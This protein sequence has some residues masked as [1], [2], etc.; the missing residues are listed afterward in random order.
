MIQVI[1]A[2]NNIRTTFNTEVLSTEL[3]ARDCKHLFF[4][5]DCKIYKEFDQDLFDRTNNLYIAFISR[6]DESIPPN[7]HVY[8]VK[9]RIDKYH[10][11]VFVSTLNGYLPSELY[12]YLLTHFPYQGKHKMSNN[13][14]TP[15]SPMPLL[16]VDIYMNDVMTKP[17]P[18]NMRRQRMIELFK[19]RKLPLAG[20]MTRPENPQSLMEAD[21][22]FIIVGLNEDATQA[23]LAWLN[24]NIQVNIDKLQLCISYMHSGEDLTGLNYGFLQSKNSSKIVMHEVPPSL[25][26]EN[27]FDY[28]VAMRA[29]LD[30]RAISRI[31]W[32]NMTFISMNEAHQVRS[33][34]LWSKYNRVA[35]V[36]CV[37]TTVARTITKNVNGMVLP[38]VVTNEDIFAKDWVICD[39]VESRHQMEMRRAKEVDQARPDVDCKEETI[40]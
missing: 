11:N 40:N 19:Q 8:L 30:G 7:I 12:N 35:N 17:Y 1:S 3:D 38:Y 6:Y 10:Y 31:D 26:G 13:Q 34:D 32:G 28:P 29:L 23:T 5:G 25:Y 27:A 4:D 9:D 33:E 36:N 22:D 18:A 14:I 24:P 16:T 2:L 20:S 15:A 39:W 21:V 37:N